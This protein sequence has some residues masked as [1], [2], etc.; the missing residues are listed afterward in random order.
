VSGVPKSLNHFIQERSPVTATL[1]AIDHEQRPD[2]TRLVVCTG[3]TLNSGIV[4]G[5]KENRLVQI[6]LDF[7]GRNERRILKAIFSRS[8]PYLG[9]PRQ[10]DLC[11]LA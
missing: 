6:S 10:V 4:L 8:M 2:V 5:N 1:S 9:D 3:K 11:G 7:R